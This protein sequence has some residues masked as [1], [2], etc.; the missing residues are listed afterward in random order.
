M[1]TQKPKSER[2]FERAREVAEHY[3]F[4][5]LSKATA[6]AST[7][8]GGKK[9]VLRPPKDDVPGEADRLSLMHAY[10]DYNF[11][12]LPSPLMVYHSEPLSK[13]MDRNQYGGK[14]AVQFSLEIIGSDRSV[15]EATLFKTT[16]EILRDAGFDSFSVVINSLG[17]KDSIARFTREFTN[18][19]KK[20]ITEVPAH[21]R[22]L[23]KKDVFKVLECAEEKCMLVKEGAPKPI[24]T[25]TEDSR[26]HFSEVLEFLESMQV[27]YS[28]NNCLVGGKDYYTR[29]IFEIRTD[30]T[31]NRLHP[32]VSLGQTLARGGRFDELA[33]RIGGKKDVP[34][35]GITLSMGGLGLIEP[36]KNSVTKNQKKPNI[37]LI[38]LGMSAKQQSFSA[39]E[40]LR[41]AKI[42]VHQSLSRDSISVQVAAA[43]KMNVPYTVIIGQ[44]EALEGTAIVR[45]MTT[46]SQ[47]TI[48][49]EALPS[50]LR[51][52]KV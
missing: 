37:Y 17:D 44:K 45:N 15:A 24:A 16:F 52:V 28:I 49:L 23:L 10:I 20:H 2:L 30:D 18:Y 32:K 40:I 47:E 21:C 29:T 31:K 7:L 51:K 34:G 22:N 50:Y 8:R 43:E 36:K 27:P 33:R 35:V 1:P 39:L 4:I 9:I 11:A 38:H 41:K 48:T 42:P 13:S 19:Y 25:L 12:T 3:G 5:P 14:G 26:T 6:N 46:R